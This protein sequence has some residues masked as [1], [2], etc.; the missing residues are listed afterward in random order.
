MTNRLLIVIAVLLTA[1][2]AWVVITRLWV[3]E[4][5]R[6]ERTLTEMQKAVES[7]D[8]KR[9]LEFV[10]PEYNYDGMDRRE[11]EGFAKSVLALSGSMQ[12]KT[13]KQEVQI[14]EH[15]QFGVTASEILSLPCPGSNLP[16]PIR[17]SWNLVFRKEG[18]AWKV[19]Q[20]ELNSING[21]PTGLEIGRAHV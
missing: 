1:L 9:C 17:T 18:A 21:Q 15:G 13:I 11:L 6:L 7:G 10:S 3:T 5:K 16:G 20:I 8:P 2:L 12:I 14:I 19:W 4:K